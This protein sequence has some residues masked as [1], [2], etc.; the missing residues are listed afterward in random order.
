MKTFFVL[1]AAF[2]A[3][4]SVCA[5]IYKYTDPATGAV[6]YSNQPKDGFVLL[7]GGSVNAEIEAI[8]RASDERIRV[9]L[10]KLQAESKKKAAVEHGAQALMQKAFP[11]CVPGRCVPEPGMPIG[12]AR[13]AFSLMYDGFTHNAAGRTV[14]YRQGASCVIF[15]DDT[16][17]TS[18]SC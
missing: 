18:V 10:K 12:T 14:R 16:K 1:F 11:R 4:Q 7:G 3:C 9:G 5:E 17:I 13:S 2:L 6:E 15:A 8:N